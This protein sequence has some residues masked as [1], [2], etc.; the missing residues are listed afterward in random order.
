MPEY[1]ERTVVLVLESASL[2]SRLLLYKTVCSAAELDHGIEMSTV[3]IVLSRV[4]T[5]PAQ[6]LAFAYLHL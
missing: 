6:R 4:K 1:C 5:V 3:L 2:E